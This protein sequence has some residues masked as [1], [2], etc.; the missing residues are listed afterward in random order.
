[1][2][3]VQPRVQG[4][5]P[6]LL[7]LYRQISPSTIG[8]LTDFGFL[9]GLQP[10]FRPIRLLGN[11]VTVRI[12]HIDSTAIRYALELAQPGDVLVVDMSGDEERACWG[13]F[14]TYAA[15]QKKLAGVIVSGCVADVRVIA[16]LGFPVYSKGIS[17]LNTRALEL[18]GEVNT[19][20]SVG[21]VSVQPGDLIVGD[22][23]GV[24]VVHPSQAEEIGRRA[25]EKERREAVKRQEYGYADRNGERGT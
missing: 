3:H 10:L 1:M 23:D 25:M 15:L 11:A 13:E 9:K 19:P 18:Q 12:P 24:F 21:G 5:T 6:E 17:A 20:I 16:G 4:V 22:D 8:H 2:F 14:R 7:E